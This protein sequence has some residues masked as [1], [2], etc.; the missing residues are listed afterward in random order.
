M[1]AAKLVTKTVADTAEQ[2]RRRQLT[3]E[4]KRGEFHA[5]LRGSHD[6][7]RQRRQERFLRDASR[8]TTQASSRVGTKQYFDRFKK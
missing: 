4:E 6:E 7:E 8:E 1:R 5:V 2:E 3:A